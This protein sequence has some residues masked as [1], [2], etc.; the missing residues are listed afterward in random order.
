MPGLDDCWVGY[1]RLGILDSS[2]DKELQMKLGFGAL[3]LF[4]FL[5]L[6]TCAVILSQYRT[7]K[8]ALVFQ[9]L[10]F[11]KCELRVGP[12]QFEIQYVE[13]MAAT[14][15]THGAYQQLYLETDRSNW[16]LLQLASKN[17][18]P[19]EQALRDSHGPSQHPMFVPHYPA[20]INR[21]QLGG[22]R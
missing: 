2:L 19:L 16:I 3:L 18:G 5:R 12:F 8:L 6:P 9:A 11:Y 15:V 14:E 4:S 1:M 13:T 22:L 7:W 10:D 20:L 17:R 21:K